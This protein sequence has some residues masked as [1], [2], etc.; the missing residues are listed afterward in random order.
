MIART[1]FIVLIVAYV[2]LSLPFAGY[3]RNRP[4]EVKLGYLP[5]P[6]L[7][8]VVTGAH[9]PTVAQM[10]V[11]R[12]LFYY[13]T[14]IQKLDEKVIVR[15]EFS[16]MYRTLQTASELD[17]YNMDVYYFAQA[18]FTWELGRVVEVNRLLE[19]GMRYRTNDFWLPFYL[20][21]NNAFF[22]KDYQKAASY[23][24]KAAEISGQPLY[25]KLAAR[26][27]YESEQTALGL[28]FLDT[29]IQVAKEPAIRK[30]YEMRRGALEASMT[31]ETAVRAFSDRF[32]QT[33]LHLDE[34]VEA[35][36]LVSL[37]ADPYG[38]E[39][40]FDE[41]GK[42]RTTSKFADSNRQK[43]TDK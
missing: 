30:T 15:P 40:Y 7:L 5:H 4:V 6:Q 21:F 12:V 17:P 37:P 28:A 14:I 31:I 26:Y 25:A 29:M 22:L 42:V 3:L 16:N 43:G 8:K 35:G 2:A 20:G 32:G 41:A 38:G 34:L 10:A 39:F 11:V 36:L 33:P 18:A 9:A 24:Q 13:G 23:Y 19:R 1:T 27:F